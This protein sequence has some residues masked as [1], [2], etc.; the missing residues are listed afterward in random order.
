MN[1]KPTQN[2]L[3]ERLLRK[4]PDFRG[5][6]RIGRWFFSQKIKTTNEVIVRGKFNCIYKLPNLR[7]TVAF[8][9]FLNGI[10]ENETHEFLVKNIEPNGV[11]LDL[12]ANVG[13]ISV[14]LSKQRPDVKVIAVEAASWIF[15]YL[16]HNVEANG[17]QHR[18][19]CIN[20]ALT[21]ISGQMLPFYSPQDKFGKGSLSP[22]FTPTAVMVESI[23]VDD[24]VAQRALKK[25]SVI[26]IDIEGFEL[27]AFK[28][29]Q[30]LLRPADSPD[31]LFEFVDWAEEC[32]KLPIG[33]AQ[34]FL[35]DMGY[36]IYAFDENGNLRQLDSVMLKGGGLLLASK[37]NLA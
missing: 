24:V 21:D 29:A 5:K 27:F 8:E 31:I 11:F 26:K 6:R 10:Y 9:I 22:V 16:Q 1:T 15:N 25:V 14:P 23:T 2:S 30:G 13:A 4:L 34:Q 20:R 32:A 12:G 35:K 37:K 19:E 17:L 18:I 28:G 33:S 36:Y 3:F 7:E